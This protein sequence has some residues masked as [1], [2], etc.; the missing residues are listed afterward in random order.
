[1][2][3]TVKNTSTAALPIVAVALAGSNP[4]HYTRTNNCPA[5]L[6]AGASCAVSVRFKP[7]STG[8]KPA[9]LVVTLGNGGV[10]K[11]VALTGTG[12]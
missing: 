10:A 11:S 7:T 2:T 12:T 6:S 9:T 8:N 3:V 5:Q 1:M 4:G